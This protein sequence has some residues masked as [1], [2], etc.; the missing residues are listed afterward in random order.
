M[1]RTDRNQRP[2]GRAQKAAVRIPESRGLAAVGR[3][4][5]V[6]PMTMAD[7]PAVMK[8]SSRIWEGNDYVPLFFDRW[9]V[10]GG[11][12]AAELRGRLV[13][14]GKATQLSPGEW[15]LEGLRVDPGRRKRGV[16]KE[17]S[18]LVLERTLDERP[19]SLRLATADVNHESLHII[20]AVMRFKP[21]AQYRF[22]VGEPAEPR[23]GPPLVTATTAEA[24]DYIAR[25]P[26]LVASK[27]LL[28]Y[29][30]LFRRFDRRYAAELVRGGHVLGFRRAGVLRGLLVLR[31]H[32]Y[33][34]N[35]LDIAFVD[36]GR[37]A[38]AAFGAFISRVAAERGTKNISGMAASDV[39]A[40]ALASLGLKPHPHIGRVLVFEYPI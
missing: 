2:E 14:Y 9:I 12:W 37:Q 40:V 23:P 32:R 25:S 6:R 1:R 17:L 20:E 35:D 28:Q 4:L 3:R 21:C 18:R 5:V 15:W 26:E 10:D 8:V 16:G 34:G 39:M 33:H 19:T 22:F 31:R 27:G 36:G 38:L 7:K 30:W 11:F 13:G 29:T 24:L